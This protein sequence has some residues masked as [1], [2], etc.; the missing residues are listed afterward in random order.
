MINQMAI[1]LSRKRSRGIKTGTP[2]SLSVR[3]NRPQIFKFELAL[4]DYHQLH[5]AFKFSGRK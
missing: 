1:A 3:P 5:P 4:T 2:S